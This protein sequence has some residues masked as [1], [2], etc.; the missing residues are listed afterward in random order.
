MSSAVPVKIDSIY[1]DDKGIHS[2]SS[3]AL[4]AQNSQSFSNIRI[5]EANQKRYTIRSAESVPSRRNWFVLCVL[6]HSAATFDAY[7]TRQASSHGASRRRSA[8]ASIRT[9]ASHLC[10]VTSGAGSDRRACAPHA[11]QPIQFRAAYLVGAA[12]CQHRGVDFRWSS[13]FGTAAA[14]I[15]NVVSKF[16][17]NLSLAGKDK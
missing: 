2:A 3:G 11:T 17:G 16:A 15:T 14:S 13:Q 9:F 10:G 1:P 12:N 4:L 8:H 5:Q 6:E 7:S